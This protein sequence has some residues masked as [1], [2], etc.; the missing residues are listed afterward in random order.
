MRLWRKLPGE[1]SELS[2]MLEPREVY[3]REN[4][5]ERKMIGKR[6]M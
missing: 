1:K 5:R 3:L 6:I 4:K 2:N